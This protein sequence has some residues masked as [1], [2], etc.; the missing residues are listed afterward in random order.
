MVVCIYLYIY[1]Y[2]WL[3]S[4]D[5]S[6]CQVL[7]WNDCFQNDLH[8][9]EWDAKLHCIM[10]VLLSVKDQMQRFFICRSKLLPVCL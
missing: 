7:G 10:P 4:D 5:V 3:F 9:V 1:L 2:S 6:T 8:C